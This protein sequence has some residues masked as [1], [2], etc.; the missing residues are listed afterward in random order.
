M[1]EVISNFCFSVFNFKRDC[2]HFPGHFP[3][4]LPC[5]WTTTTK[6][7]T[8]KV[9]I[10]FKAFLVLIRPYL[11]HVLTP[12]RKALSA[13]SVGGVSTCCWLYFTL[14]HTQKRF[15]SLCNAF[16]WSSLTFSLAEYTDSDFS[17]LFHLFLITLHV[18]LLSYS[19]WNWFWAKFLGYIPV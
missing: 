13:L 10:V 6:K 4:K 8:F 15:C 11:S 1:V 16:T 14:Q 2:L 12:F 19:A 5:N 9:S 7:K 17:P 18:L 3:S